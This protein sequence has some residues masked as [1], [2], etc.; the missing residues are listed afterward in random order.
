MLLRRFVF[1]RITLYNETKLNDFSSFFFSLSFFSGAI[2]KRKFSA[3][4]VQVRQAEPS[5]DPKVRPTPGEQEARR[6]EKTVEG[7]I[8]DVQDHRRF[9]NSK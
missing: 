3:S 1:H 2:F 7:S 4:D 9:R 5:L 8:L 6:C